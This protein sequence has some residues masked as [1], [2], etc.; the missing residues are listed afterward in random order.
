MEERRKEV[1]TLY[2]SVPHSMKKI[3][4]RIGLFKTY[5]ATT[6]DISCIG[7]SFTTVEKLGHDMDSG[8]QVTIY[9]DQ[10]NSEVKAKIVHSYK[11]DET[12]SRIGIIFT[13]DK[14]M[15]QYYKLLQ[16]NSDFGKNC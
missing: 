11:V 7:M 5:A 6:S 15:K 14:S 2:D 4:I 3:Q 16:K 9:F 10:L 8:K 13:D 1:R 12:K